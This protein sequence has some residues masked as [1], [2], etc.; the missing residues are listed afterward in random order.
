MIISRTPFRASFVGGGSDLQQFYSRSGYGAV[1]SSA[2]KQYMYIV[3]HPYFH[4]KIRIKY[5]RT[6]DVNVIDEI[7]HPI[8]RECLKKVGVDKGIEIASFADVSAGTGLG[9]SSAFTVGLL[10][11]LY[12]YKGKTVSKHQLATEACEIEIDIL[13]EPIGKQ[14]QFAVSYGNINHIRFNQDE[15]VEVSPISLPESL[16]KELESSLRLYYVGGERRSRDILSRQKINMASNSPIVEELV[17][18][19]Y[20]VEKLKKTIIAGEFRKTGAI[21]DTWWLCKIKLAEGITSGTINELYGTAKK[22]GATGGKLLGAGGAGFLL[23]CHQNHEKLSRQLNCRSLPFA[24]DTE[25]SKII[26]NGG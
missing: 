2:I 6:E 26:F 10:N 3:I 7:K 11:A 23:M 25:G 22:N 17:K 13:K 15:T 24:V 18:S 4:D 20:L 5:S 21:L 8:V 14:D 16:I 1:I 9:S 12:A 19:L